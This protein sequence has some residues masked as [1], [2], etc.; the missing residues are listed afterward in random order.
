[1]QMDGVET[2]D[3]SS[4]SDTLVNLEFTLGRPSLNMGHAGSSSND[5]TLLKC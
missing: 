3:K 2:A 1:M 4:S 5:S